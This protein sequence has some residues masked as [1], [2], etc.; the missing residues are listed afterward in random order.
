MLL[1]NVAFSENGTDFTKLC[2]VPADADPFTIPFPI[3]LLGQSDAAVYYIGPKE[4][5]NCVVNEREAARVI[6]AIPPAIIF[7]TP[8]N[9]SRPGIKVFK[10]KIVSRQGGYEVFY[11]K[12]LGEHDKWLRWDP[13]AVR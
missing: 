7:L 6:W 3:D 13:T 8:D 4:A 11:T 2:L 9:P 12:E 10:L 5:V 1:A